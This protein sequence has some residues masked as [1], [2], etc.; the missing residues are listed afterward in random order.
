MIMASARLHHAVG[1][2]IDPKD[3]I[4]GL[5]RGLTVI[6]AFDREHSKMTASDVGARTGLARTAARR[7]L[8][9][10]CH[11]G[12]AQ[13]DGKFF[14]LTP[15]VLRLGESYLDAARLLRQVQPAIDFLS[16]KTSETVNVSVLEG[17]DVVYVA[18]SNSPRP[19]LNV[20]PGLR[21]AAHLVTSG[22]TMLATLDDEVVQRWIAEHQFTAFTAKTV[23][24]PGVFLAN[25]QEARKLGYW[26]IEENLDT[27]LLGV[28]MA[29]RNTRGATVAAVGMTLHVQ[30]WPRAAV[31]AK[32][33]PA[34]SETV[35]AIRPLL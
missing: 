1:F 28:A 29:V 21:V 9:T 31:V 10:L 30:S 25:V 6:E 23:T 13:T 8:L 12:Y 33:V 20:Y 18:R 14:W 26:V 35:Q 34:L 3:N 2:D 4:E 19:A 17:H 16:A 22:V 11:L 5:A 32:L 27:G 24:D 7:Y 15:R